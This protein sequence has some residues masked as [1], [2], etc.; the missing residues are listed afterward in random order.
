M[1]SAYFR[2]T[3]GLLNDDIAA[4]ANAK[5]RQL[6]ILTFS[7]LEVRKHVLGTERSRDGL[8]KDF[9]TVAHL[10]AG[11]MSEC[12]VLVAASLLLLSLQRRS[13]KLDGAQVARERGA[14]HRKRSY[15]DRWECEMRESE[16]PFVCGGSQDANRVI[17]IFR[18]QE[19]LPDSG[20]QH[21]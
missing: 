6:A 21:G 2:T 1:I 5:Q 13:R 11:C 12:D 3:V 10:L 17:E 4:S 18:Q 20:S 7:L 14:Q 16:S 9:D 8:C 15:S 19:K